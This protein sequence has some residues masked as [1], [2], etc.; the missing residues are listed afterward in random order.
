VVRLSSLGDAV[1][2]EPVFRAVKSAR[3]GARTLLLVKRAFAGI[4]EG[5]PAVDEVWVFE[6]R[7]FWGWLAEMRRR[8]LDLFLDLHGTWRSVL[9]GF[10]SGA[11]VRAR[12]DKAV[13][14]RRALVWFKRTS[15]ALGR[16][17]TDRYLE[18]AERS[19]IR[20]SARR[21]R[22]PAL[23]DESWRRRLGPGPLLAVAPGAQ[24]A[25]KRWPAD[26]F[27]AAADELAARWPPDGGPVRVVVLGGPDDAAAAGDVLAS[28]KT[29]ALD[30]A[31]RTS[32]RDL[33]AVLPLCGLLL[34]NDSG[35]MHL[36]GALSVPTVAVFGSTVREFG[37]FP[38]DPT[39][40]VVQAEGLECR[41]CALHGRETCPRG[42]WR[43]LRDVAVRDVVEAGLRAL[44]RRGGAR[45]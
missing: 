10:L 35:A 44:A 16:L 38:A 40:E 2:A 28:L 31:G 37:F 27:A 19:G 39:A 11:S 5:H 7:G 36:A 23:A 18:A 29:P 9:W 1:L 8:R 13:W 3:P 33:R 22:L 30:L 20:A 43:C 6:D 12:Y 21:P 34:T 17:V 15:P 26:R 14:P 25:T 45:A 41:P 24:H 4:Y 32:V 42:H